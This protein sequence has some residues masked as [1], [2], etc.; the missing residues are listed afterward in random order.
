MQ[1]L[2]V[3]LVLEFEAKVKTEEIRIRSWNQIKMDELSVMKFKSEVEIKEIKKDE[4]SVMVKSENW[5]NYGYR[6]LKLINLEM[7]NLNT[8]RT[9][10]V[11]I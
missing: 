1:I 2:G 3:V 9:E 7:M 8:V 6:K 11:D 10:I 5:R 4:L